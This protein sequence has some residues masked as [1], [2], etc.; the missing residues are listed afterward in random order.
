MPLAASIV[1][2]MSATSRRTSSSTSVMSTL[3][4]RRTATDPHDTRALHHNGGTAA[5]DRHPHF[6]ESLAFDFLDVADPADDA[7]AGHDFVA[8]LEPRQQLG[9]ALPGLA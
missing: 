8:F 7:A 9:V 6:L 4:W 5:L 2:N 1:S 3:C